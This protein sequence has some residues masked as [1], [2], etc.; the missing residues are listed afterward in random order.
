MNYCRWNG[1]II[2]DDKMKFTIELLGEKNVNE[3]VLYLLK[4]LYSKKEA[5]LNE[6]F[7]SSV[8]ATIC[9]LEVFGERVKILDQI[10]EK[11][12]KEKILVK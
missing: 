3:K 1:Y 9:L 10:F 7:D 11:N 5:I 6:I 8:E 4:G 2:P 12:E